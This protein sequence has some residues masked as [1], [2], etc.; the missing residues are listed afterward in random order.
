M[1][2]LHGKLSPGATQLPPPLVFMASLGLN[3]DVIKNGLV[4][5]AQAILER[6]AGRDIVVC[7]GD[8]RSNRNLAQAIEQQANGTWKRC[9][10]HLSA[11]LNSLPHYQPHPR[12]PLGHSFYETLNRKA[13]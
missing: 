12:P 9:P 13:T 2:R 8:L 7:G 6:K 1:R 3:G 5:E 11:G 10:P 4:S